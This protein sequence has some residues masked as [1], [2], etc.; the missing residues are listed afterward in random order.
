MSRT[1]PTRTALVLLLAGGLLLPPAAVPAAPGGKAE[2]TCR[3][4]CA[5][6]KRACVRG[7]K[8][9]FRDT[10]RRCMAQRTRGNGAVVRGCIERARETLD[11]ESGECKRY[12]AEDCRT[13]CTAG[14]TACAARCGDAA[15]ARGEQCET[16]RDCGAGEV[17]IGCVCTAA[18]FAPDT[19]EALNNAECLLPYPSS[20]FLIPAD[21]PTGFRLAIPQVGIP[22]P[23]GPPVP[24]DPLNALDGFSPTVQILMHFPQGVDP[25]RSD[26]SRLLSPGCCGQPAGPPWIDTRTYD[27]RSLDPDS[28]TVLLDADTGERILH[29]IEPDA[30]AAGNP[31]RQ[32][33][34]MRPGRSLTPGHRYIVAMRDLKTATGEGVVAE[35]AF[36]ALRDGKPTGVTA[37]ENRRAYMDS[38][39]FTALERHGVARGGLVLAFDF[40]VQS[41]HQLTHQMLVMRD[42]AYAWLDGVAADP[43]D[44]PFEVTAVEAR[45]CGAPGETVW[46]RVSGTYRSPLFLDGDLTGDRAQFMNV[47]GN[48]TPVVNGFTNP[49]FT[50]AIPCGIFDGDAGV[51]RSA[52][53]GHGLF[54]TGADMVTLVTTAVELAG[55]ELDF[56]AGATDWRGLSSPDLAWIGSHVVGLGQ[57]RLHNF[58]A[59]PDRLRQ[60]MVNTL[61]LARLMKI[62]LFNRHDAFQRPGGGG[63]FPG[64]PGEVYY[65]GASLGGIMGTFLAALTPDIKRFGIDVPAINFSCLLQRS[66]QYTPFESLLDGIGLTDPMQVAL[67]I[68]LLHELWVAGEPA[69]YARHVTTDPLPGSGGPKQMLMTVAWLDKQVSNQCTEI[70]AR[71]LGLSNLEGSLVR[72]WQEIPDTV[73]PQDSGVIVYSTGSFDLFDPA[74]EPFIPPLSNEI[75][76]AVC[77]PHPVRSLIPAGMMQ[78]LE[79]LRPGGR[80][81]NFCDGLCD[82]ATAFEQPLG[83]VCDPL[84]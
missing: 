5:R 33:L 63:V 51:T 3:K 10:K 4:E 23:T 41:E 1:N 53:L 50:I 80:I 68:G 14:G 6:T 56:I 12:A 38:Q 24:P 70:A 40:V 77:D 71:T 60:G 18:L 44:V 37:I 30:R 61:V 83:G 16:A 29:F 42:R 78:I 59:L 36:A 13:C 72:G 28:P 47:D 75:P 62:G 65:F 52:L 26:A 22:Q 82:A 81:E 2:R 15:V 66:T 9:I 73:G 34:F 58:E 43:D 74:H 20:R 54:G 84:G 46:R 27:D 67:G 31:E 25:A 7:S 69:G 19:C 79:F 45:D 21:T 57:S 11:A 8:L 48:D 32:L 64:P 76:S 55:I 35:P 17:C 49:P 39:V